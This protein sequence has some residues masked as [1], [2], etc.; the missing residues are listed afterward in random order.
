MAEG[1][2]TCREVV[3]VINDYLEG[4][5]APIERERVA[6]HL[7]D[8]PMC[9]GYLAQLSITVSA[10]R[11]LAEADLDPVMCDELMRAFRAWRREGTAGA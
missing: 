10:T 6:R 8:C 5:L 4:A 9:R 1:A 11:R 3:E 2:L 7:D